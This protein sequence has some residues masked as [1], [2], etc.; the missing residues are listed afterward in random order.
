MKD[1]SG[2]LATVHLSGT[3]IL[4]YAP[5]SGDFDYLAFV[6]ASARAPSISIIVLQAN[7]ILTWTGGGQLQLADSLNGPWTSTGNTSGLAVLQ[8]DQFKKFARVCVGCP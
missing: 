6:P 4:R 8:I 1:A 7:F 3:Q 5:N 2:N